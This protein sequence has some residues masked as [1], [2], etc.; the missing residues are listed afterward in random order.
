MKVSAL[1][2]AGRRRAAFAIAVAMGVPALANTLAQLRVYGYGGSVGRLEIELFDAD[3]PATVANFIR[4]VEAGAW[5]N[6]FFHRLAPGFVMQGGGYRLT[7]SLDGVEAVPHFGSITNEFDVG[8]LRSNVR[9]T[10]AMAKL[11]GD[12]DSA[13]CQFFINLADNSANLDHQNGGFTVFGRVLADPDGMLDFWNTLAMGYGIVDAGEPFSSLPVNY[14]GTSAP[15]LADL[16]YCD[17]SLFRVAVSNTASGRILWW[18]SAA[19]LSNIIE[20]ASSPAGPWTPLFAAVGDG[21]PM[22]HT[23]TNAVAGARFYRLRVDAAAP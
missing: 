12:P 6:M 13:T 15:T 4:L 22:T 21:Q 23:D 14:A 8:P 7:A 1:K 16:V 3:K 9:G 18:M 2:A 20:A 19:G 10:L 17:V 5:R 11:P